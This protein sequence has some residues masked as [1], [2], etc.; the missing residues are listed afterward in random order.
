MGLW[1]PTDRNQNKRVLVIV[2]AAGLFFE[3]LFSAGLP[4]KHISEHNGSEYNN[5][6]WSYESFE[7]TNYI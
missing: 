2:V 5:V 1:F 4:Y 3:H 6:I 7:D